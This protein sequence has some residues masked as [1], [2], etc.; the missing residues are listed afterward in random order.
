MLTSPFS[1]ECFT[2]T[3]LSPSSFLSNILPEFESNVQ[4]FPPSKS[5]VGSANMTSM[6][7]TELFC[8]LLLFV[9]QVKEKGEIYIK[10]YSYLNSLEEAS[11]NRKRK[12]K[13]KTF[14]FKMVE[15]ILTN[16]DKNKATNPPS[17]WFLSGKPPSSVT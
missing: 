9:V 17:K 8:Y 14:L 3:P 15:K 1:N 16:N 10:R 5:L 11:R 13:T 2:A 4:K 12:K 7:I 6:V